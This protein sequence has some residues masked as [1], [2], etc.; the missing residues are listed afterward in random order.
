MTPDAGALPLAAIREAA[1]N[2]E[3]CEEVEALY[4]ELEAQIA[5]RQPVC[6][7]RGECCN[8]GGY[9]HRLFVTPVEVAYFLARPHGAVRPP[10]GSEACPYHVDGRC[11]ARAA[12]PA[13]CRIFYCDPH[14]RHWQSPLTEEA[15][16]RLKGLHGRFGLPYAYVDWMEAL[17]VAAVGAEV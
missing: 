10:G 4:A 8:F 15:L 13:G 1:A 2:A 16:A 17:R 14:S 3:F 5:A 11:D 9:G 12:R 6:R 7:N